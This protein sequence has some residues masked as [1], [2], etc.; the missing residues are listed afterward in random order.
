MYADHTRDAIPKS[1]PYGLLAVVICALVVL[2]MIA[3]ALFDAFTHPA[4][5]G[6][7]RLGQVAQPAP[8]VQPLELD[9]QRPL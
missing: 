5:D 7:E 6:L 8:A 1:T 3:W 4:E 9:G 2:A